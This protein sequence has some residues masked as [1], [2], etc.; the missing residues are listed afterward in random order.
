MM[1]IFALE[2]YCVRVRAPKYYYFDDGREN[3][4]AG[5][6]KYITT[7]CKKL[8][9]I[10]KLCTELIRHSG[11]IHVLYY[12]CYSSCFFHFAYAFTSHFFFS[13]M[14]VV[15]GICWKLFSIPFHLKFEVIQV[16][17]SFSSGRIDAFC[18]RYVY[19]FFQHVCFFTSLCTPSKKEK[20][21]FVYLKSVLSTICTM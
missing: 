4:N 14:N 21:Q 13:K 9:K 1:P 6:A 2:Y 12:S 5:G 17:H 15:A 11:W 20:F 18:R 19:L 16:Y 3:Q 8:F 10:C 7:F